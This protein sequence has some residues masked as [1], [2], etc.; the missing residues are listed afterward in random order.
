MAGIGVLF[1]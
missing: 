1:G